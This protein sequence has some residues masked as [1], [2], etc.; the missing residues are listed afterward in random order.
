M[1]LSQ[2]RRV[3]KSTAQIRP[4]RL[5]PSLVQAWRFLATQPGSI[6][7]VALFERAVRR[8]VWVNRMQEQLEHTTRTLRH[9]PSSVLATFQKILSRPSYFLA[10][11]ESRS[12]TVLLGPRP[13]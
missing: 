2:S 10:L 5:S 13:T 3:R 9:N 4:A 6:E 11:P 1:G 12:W 7:A 8:Q